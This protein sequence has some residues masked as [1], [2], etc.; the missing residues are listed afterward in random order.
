MPLEKTRWSEADFDDLSWHDNHI[1]SIHFDCHDFESRLRLEI[2]HIVE[3]TKPNP[4]EFAF[5]VAPASLVFDHVTDLRIDIEFDS[6]GYQV[7]IHQVSIHQIS[8]ELVPVQKICLDRPY[9]IWT[10]E[11]NWPAGEISFGASGFSQVLRANPI[12]T[13]EQQLSTHE[14]E[15][16]IHK[17]MR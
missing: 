6:S 12:L 4:E 1:H 11:T 5:W 8:R 15:N 3:W 10:I 9:Y 13:G 16:L 17:G 14:R 7:V 2:D